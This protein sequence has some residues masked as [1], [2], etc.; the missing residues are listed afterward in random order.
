MEGNFSVYKEEIIMPKN[1]SCK[2]KKKKEEELGKKEDRGQKK[3]RKSP[4][5]RRVS[6]PVLSKHQDV[7][8]GVTFPEGQ[9]HVDK[10]GN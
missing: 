7:L 3:K 8:T 6:M 1:S 4:E 5:K 9:D 2:K 10:K